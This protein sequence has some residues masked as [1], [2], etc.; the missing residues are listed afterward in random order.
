MQ[1]LESIKNSTKHHKSHGIHAL[2]ME[3]EAGNY[4]CTHKHKYDHLSILAKGKAIVKTLENGE[5]VARMFD[6]THCPQTIE[7][8]AE[9]K[10]SIVA[11]TDIVWF[12]IH[13]HFH[14]EGET[15][16]DIEDALIVEVKNDSN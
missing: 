16:E 8:K 2:E 7:I 5:L 14:K 3:V 11:V 12:C 13:S 1:T 6:A 10:H 9:L 15:A 4:V